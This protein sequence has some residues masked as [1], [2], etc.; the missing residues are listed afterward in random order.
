MLRLV[1]WI[2]HETIRIIPAVIFFLIAFNL[3]HFTAG[4]TLGPHETQYFSYVG[5]S[6]GAL[7]VGKVLIIADSLPLINVFAGKPLIYNITWRFFIYG[8]LV[9][10]FWTCETLFELFYKYDDWAY[11]CFRLQHEMASPIFWGSL[12]WLLSV[13]LIFIVFTEFVRVLGMKKVY[14]MLFG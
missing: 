3:I 8:S 1:K 14:R 7:I 4:L 9:V 11:A 2:Q 10:L 5:V 13:F 6:V 12:L